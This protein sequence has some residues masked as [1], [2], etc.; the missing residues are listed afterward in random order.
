MKPKS[1]RVK[2]A[3]RRHAPTTLPNSQPARPHA[4]VPADRADRGRTAPSILFT[5]RNPVVKAAAPPGSAR[6][7]HTRRSGMRARPAV[8]SPTAERAGVGARCH[9]ADSSTLS[10]LRTISTPYA[11]PRSI[12][13]ERQRCCR[14]A[15]RRE[16]RRAISTKAHFR[17]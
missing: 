16:P 17:P 9:G 8:T 4:S 15:L 5:A 13:R 11:S 1:R 12:S 7:R 6:D 3:K 10:I 2:R 14:E